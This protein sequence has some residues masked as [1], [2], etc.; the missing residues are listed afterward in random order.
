MLQKRSII[1][2]VMIKKRELSKDDDESD[3][4]PHMDTWKETTYFQNF[5]PLHLISIRTEMGT[6]TKRLTVTVLQPSDVGAED[7]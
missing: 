5:Q 1:Y 4:S 7:L 6:N 2:E 3:S